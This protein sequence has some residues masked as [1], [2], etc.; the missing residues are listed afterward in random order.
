LEPSSIDT[1][2]FGVKDWDTDALLT[3]EGWTESRR[4]LMFAVYNTPDS[5]DL[6]LFMG[7]GPEETRHR[8]FEM[9]ANHDVF[10][11]P[12][13]NT[14]NA[15]RARS[16]PAIFTRHLLKRE[17]YENLD[18]EEREQEIRKRWDE[19]LDKDLSRIEAAL[20]KETWI[21]EAVEPEQRT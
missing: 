2:R 19:F 13:P 9:A 18:Q 1:I 4:I 21:W 8:L 12:R 6:H 5:L 10:F 17:A 3:A 7:P 14:A 11:E 20:K 15:I 16:W